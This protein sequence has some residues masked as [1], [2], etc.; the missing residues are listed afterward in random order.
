MEVRAPEKRLDL[1][2]EVHKKKALERRRGPDFVT[3]MDLFSEVR[4]A[5]CPTPFS[6]SSKALSKAIASMP[7]SLTGLSTK[8]G[9]TDQVPWSPGARCPTPPKRRVLFPLPRRSN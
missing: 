3:G 1:R 2:Q 7:P 4:P 5:L 9:M 6:L 8:N